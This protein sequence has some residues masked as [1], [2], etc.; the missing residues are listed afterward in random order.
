M[1]DFLCGSIS[2][3]FQNII[4]HPFDT[5]KILQQNNKNPLLKNP[6]YYYKGIKYPMMSQAILTGYNFQS[7][8]FF[9]Q[10][11]HNFYISG[12]LGGITSSPIIFLFDYFKLMRQMNKSYNYNINNII[13]LN[14][15]PVTILR[16]CNAISIYYGTY[17]YLN[18]KMDYSVFLSGSLS[19]VL[20]WGLTYP[21]DVI[22]TRQMTYNITFKEALKRGNLLNGIQI[23]LI[24]A[25]LVNSIAFYSYE[26]SKKLFKSF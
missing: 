3:L 22:K 6:L 24:R 10:Y 5:F 23:C 18:K 1:I 13:K 2:G 17:D 20:S 25:F 7:I 16:E 19:G 4:G 14:G 12:F 21:L 8:M 15:K 11:I 26:Q 9:N